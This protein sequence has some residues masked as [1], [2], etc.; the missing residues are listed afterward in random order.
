MSR[1]AVVR[2]VPGAPPISNVGGRCFYDSSVAF[3]RGFQLFK[4]LVFSCS[5]LNR[6]GLRHVVLALK[7]G[8]LARQQHGSFILCTR[9]AA[10]LCTKYKV[11]MGSL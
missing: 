3:S 6:F 1:P 9:A 2:Q 4:S 11:P 5:F 8:K 10:V 7:M